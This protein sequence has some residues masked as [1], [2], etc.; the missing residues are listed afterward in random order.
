MYEEYY[1][2][3]PDAAAYLERIGLGGEKIP[4]N[5]AGLDRLICAHLTHVPFENLVE[6]FDHGCPDL[7]VPALF[8]KIV[9]RRRGGYCFELNGAFY[10]LL[11]ALGFT[12]YPVACRVRWLHSERSPL[13][14]RGTIAVI[15]G[16]KF[17]CDVG[18]GGP[19]PHCAVPFST[20]AEGGF[21]ITVEGEETQVRRHTPEGDE[22]IISF[23]DNAFDPIDFIPLNF[24]IAMA[25]GSYFAMAPM[26]NLVTEEGSIALNGDTL[27]IHNGGEATEVKVAPEEQAAV[28]DK[29][30]GIRL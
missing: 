24:H 16:E 27:R 19:S 3:L 5:R 10:A 8:D 23:E 29:Y 1:A 6:C 21:F 9:T 7:R 30:F 13:S 14:H 2:P 25:P 17:Y 28:M 15:D 26:L 22:M 18:F 12:V 4:L 11:K 20:E